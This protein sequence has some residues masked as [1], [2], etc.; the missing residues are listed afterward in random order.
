MFQFLET[1]RLNNGRL[2]KLDYHNARLKQTL[3]AFYPGRN[4]LLSQELAAAS[5]QKGLYKCRVIY[6]TEIRKVEFVRYSLPKIRSLKVVAADELN[7]SFKFLDREGINGLFHQREKA[8]DVLLVQQGLFTDTSFCN[9]LFFN[10]KTWLTPAH[11]LLKGTQQQFLLEKGLVHTADIRP[12]DLHHFT[13]IRLVNAMIRF[14]D[15][16]DI[17]PDAIYF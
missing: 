1:I 9:V 15:A 6:D 3:S 4:L 2:E 7:Y 5:P 8:S 12:Q 13:K 10:G 14:D 11:P 17:S 16:L